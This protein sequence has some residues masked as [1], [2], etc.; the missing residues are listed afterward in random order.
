MIYEMAEAESISL[1]PPNYHFYRAM[2]F[3]AVARAMEEHSCINLPQYAEAKTRA[4]FE[5]AKG[6]ESLA[7]QISGKQIKD[8]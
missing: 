5:T 8:A 2:L 6:L 7:Y 3:G 1:H 4:I